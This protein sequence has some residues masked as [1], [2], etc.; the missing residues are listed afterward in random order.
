M[1]FPLVSAEI[2]DFNIIRAVNNGMMPSIY[3]LDNPRR[4]MQA[5]IEI[6][7]KEEIQAEVLVRNLVG[8]GNFLKAAALTD[9]EMVNYSNIAQDCAISAKTV[10]EYFSIL[11]DTLIGYMI[12]AYS[13]VPK[14]NVVLAPRFYFFDVSIPNYLLNRRD[15]VP[16]SVEFG[17]AFEHIV[18]QE[19]VAYL[20]YSNKS[21][22]ISYWHTYTGIE[23]DV[24]LG[25]AEV[26]IELKSATEVRSSHVKNLKRFAEDYPN[27][28]LIIVSLDKFSRKL[29]EVENLYVYD[30][31]RQLWAGR[32]F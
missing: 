26:A 6:Y 29:G 21:D 24:V 4:Q 17:H 5:Y 10:K 13:K 1:L 9:G 2:P 23:V 19:I 16:G 11:T 27:A 32:I 12:P 20:G 28:R 31:L 7:L 8:F 18:V 22:S 15:L 14:R 3:P 25:D 30:F